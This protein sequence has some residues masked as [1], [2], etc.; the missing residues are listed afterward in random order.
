MPDDT[1]RSG[2][3]F[4]DRSLVLGLNSDYLSLSVE[5]PGKPRRFT[6]TYRFVMLAAVVAI[7]FFIFTPPISVQTG[8][9]TPRFAFAGLKLPT[10]LDNFFY[11]VALNFKTA[12]PCR[13]IDPLADGGGGGWSP[14]G[15]QVVSL[16]SNCYDELAKRLHDPALCDAVKP[17]STLTLDGSGMNKSGCLANIN[18]P[19]TL[20]GPD[21]H[22]MRPFVRILQQLGYGD[23]QVAASLH[24][25]LTYNDYLPYIWRTLHNDPQ[26][27]AR[28]NGSRS[29]AEPPSAAHLRPAHLLEFL[30]QM[31]AVDNRSPALCG[32]ISQNSTFMDHLGA[33]ALLRS[34]CYIALAHN[35]GDDR[36][37]T[38][39]PRSGSFPDINNAYD[40]LESCQR[41]VASLNASG[42]QDGPP[43]FPDPAMLTLALI[44]IG[45]TKT[46]L[47]GLVSAPTSDDYW[48]F[49]F[50]LALRGSAPDRNQFLARVSQ[51]R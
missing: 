31:A 22:N 7:L 24:R 3:H 33:T 49:L 51:L 46:E 5:M 48:E 50:N 6:S 35:T 23:Q 8:P 21:P 20:A 34:R 18:G 41:A 45:Y 1:P 47:A 44:E 15:F 43:V 30:Y 16:K 2:P 36:L 11:L 12:E 13:K 28:L 37:C 32:R 25:L 10:D 40:S 26:F 39:L 29:Y 19:L 38:Q 9:A 17:V 14:R 42:L 27:I 4:P